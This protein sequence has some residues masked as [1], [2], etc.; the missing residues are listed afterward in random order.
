M[1]RILLLPLLQI[2]SG[3]QHVADSIIAHLEQNP[4]FSCEKIELLSHCYSLLER[5]V[6]AL[7][8]QTINTIPGLYSSLYKFVAGKQKGNK[9][10]Y[11]YEWLFL[12]KLENLLA[13]KN[14]DLIICTHSL[15]SYLVNRLKEEH[16]WHGKTIN[17]YTDFFINNLWG[18]RNIDY[19]FVPSPEVKEQLIKLDV[20]EE[21]IY[22]TG[23]PVHPQLQRTKF[24]IQASRPVVLISAGSMGCGAIKQLLKRLQPEGYIDYKVLCGKNEQLF[25]FV[26]KLD[27][28]FIEPLPYIAS[29]EMINRLYDDAACILT[30]PGGVT[31]SE[32]L[33]KK[34]PI[35]I[36]QALP[37]QEEYN[38]QYLKKKNLA[39]H[40]ANWKH[41]QNIEK[42]I[43]E[44]IRLKRERFRDRYLHFYEHFER[45]EIRDLIEKI[46]S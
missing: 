36:F 42:E 26:Q 15:P 40:L 33:Y 8:I 19:H 6:T 39:F 18:I 22:V 23:I 4:I 27:S 7:Y 11:I 32:C 14:P 41:S 45:R 29:K 44:Y 46:I 35:I 31:M 12:E 21:R 13:E 3:H 2:P 30:K 24:T 20:A 34:L 16:R 10:F 17:V 38:L 25:Q 5:V 28:P 1:A 43:Y 37:G 9:K